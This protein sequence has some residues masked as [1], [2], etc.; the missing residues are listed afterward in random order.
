MNG[1][2]SQTKEFFIKSLG[3]PRKQELAG[4][5]FDGAEVPAMIAAGFGRITILEMAREIKNSVIEMES[6]DI[7]IPRD[8]SETVA[9]VPAEVEVAPI[10]VAVDHATGTDTTVV[11]EP[12]APVEPTPDVPTEPVVPTP[13]A[14]VTD[15][16]AT[17]PVIPT[18]P[19]APTAPTA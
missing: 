8:E 13:D 4:M 6:L 11:T 18:E 19:T 17:D 16:T 7:D 14:T 9:D 3:H 1:N 2:N 5:I 12:T 10:N 15:A